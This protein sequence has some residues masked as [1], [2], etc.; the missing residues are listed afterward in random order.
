MVKPSE[1]AKKPPHRFFNLIFLTPEYRSMDRPASPSIGCNLVRWVRERNLDAPSALTSLVTKDHQDYCGR[2]S[3]G[4]RRTVYTTM[5]APHRPPAT[6][7]DTD[8]VKVQARDR[9]R[10]R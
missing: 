9:G 3:H 1:G 2:I 10:W 4:N 7:I 5:Q 8:G 6:T